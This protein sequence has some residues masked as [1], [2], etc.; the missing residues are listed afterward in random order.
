MLQR[1]TDLLIPGGRLVLI[2][3]YWH[4]G[5]GLHA[6]QIIEALPASLRDVVFYNLSDQAT[7]WGN[8]VRDERYAVVA[9]L[10]AHLE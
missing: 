3:G 8:P 10:P 9:D 1:W 4:T 5:G 2:E 6:Q 7:L